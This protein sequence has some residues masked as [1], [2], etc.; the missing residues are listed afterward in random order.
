[1]PAPQTHRVAISWGQGKTSGDDVR[2]AVAAQN[3]ARWY[4]ESG[5]LAPAEL[6][7]IFLLRE[8]EGLAYGEI[9]KALEILDGTVGSRLNRARAELREHLVEFGWDF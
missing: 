8:V 7:C 3:V 4:V 9:A 1:M 2:L 6:R 5:R